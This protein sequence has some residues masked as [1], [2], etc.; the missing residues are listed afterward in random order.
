MKRTRIV[1]AAL[2]SVAV[3]AAVAGY[4]AGRAR[5]AGIPTM[6]PL[7]YS[8]TLTDGNGV[9]LSGMK[10]VQVVLVNAASGSATDQCGDVAPTPVSLVAGSFQV[11]LPDSCQA[12]VESKQDLWVEV[13]VDGMSMG[14]TKLGAV[15]YALESERASAAAGALDTRI[16]NLETS[17]TSVKLKTN[18]FVPCQPLTNFRTEGYTNV[19]VRA[20]LYSDSGCTKPVPNDPEGCHPW[21]AALSIRDPANFNSTCCGVAPYYTNG[22]VDVVAFKP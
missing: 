22:I 11:K 9:P 18:P 17:A 21:C 15:P 14:R 2:A 8:G 20:A 7:V 13:F 4:L 16:A 3:V 10:N 6:G 1:V 19:L 5:A 12:L